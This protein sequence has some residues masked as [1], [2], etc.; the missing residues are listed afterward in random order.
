MKLFKSPLQRDR[1]FVAVNIIWFPVC[2]VAVVSLWSF[3]HKYIWIASAIVNL[4]AMI[5]T[6][7]DIRAYK[8][9]KVH[10]GEPVFLRTEIKEPVAEKV[11]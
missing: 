9:S 1:W 4:W 7:R 6:L 10:V 2:A 11:G 3:W 8:Q 5:V